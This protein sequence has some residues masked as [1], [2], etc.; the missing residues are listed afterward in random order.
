MVAEQLE[1]IRRVS[2]N[3][4]NTPLASTYTEGHCGNMKQIIYTTNQRSLGV[5]E[6]EKQTYNKKKRKSKSR[7]SKTTMYIT[8][9]TH[10][11]FYSLSYQQICTLFP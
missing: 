2:R 9:K 3:G 10:S 6:K 8:I 4:A 5:G 1:G 7:K 11:C